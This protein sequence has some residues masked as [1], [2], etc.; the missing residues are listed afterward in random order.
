MEHLRYKQRR[1]TV[2]CADNSD[3]SGVRQGK[4]ER[5]GKKQD[6]QNTELGGDTKKEQSGFCQKRT[7]VDHSADTDK[8]QQRKRLGSG[9]ARFIEP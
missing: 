4:A 6:D 9:N 8:E 1:R 7:K 5:A 2:G 3:G